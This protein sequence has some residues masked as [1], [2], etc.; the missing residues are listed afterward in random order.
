[1]ETETTFA[2]WLKIQRKQ[3]DIT[4]KQLANEVGCSVSAIRKFEIGAR[5]P[6]KQIAELIAQALNIPTE[7]H[8]RFIKFARSVQS[9]NKSGVFYNSFA[10][11]LDSQSSEAKLV[12]LLTAQARSNNLPFQATNFIGRKVELST[13]ESLVN[14]SAIRLITIVGLGGMGKTRLAISLAEK[15]LADDKFKH[16]CYFV[17]LAA[18]SSSD[19]IPTAIAEAFN[20]S[21]DTQENQR[22]ISQQVLAYLHN[23]EV[24]LILDNFEHLLKG[25]EIVNQIL[26]AAPQLKIIATSRERLSLYSER[27]FRLEGLRTHLKGDQE[28]ASNSESDQLF[29]QSAQ[30]INP[31]FYLTA[32]N[33]KLVTKIC[34]LVGGMPLAIELAAGWLDTLSLSVI[35]AEIQKNLDLLNS[36]LSDLASRHQSIRAVLN[37]SWDQLSAADAT[38]LANFS[39]FRN[40][41]TFEAATSILGVSLSTLK[42]FVDKSLL[43][44]QPNQNR[45]QIHELMRQ[46][47]VE[48]KA[49]HQGESDYVL[50]QHCKYYLTQAHKQEQI[51]KGEDQQNALDTIESEFE[52]IRAAWCYAVKENRWS[53]LRIAAGSLGYFCKW[54]GRYLEGEQLFAIAVEGSEKTESINVYFSP[55]LAIFANIKGN[56]EYADSLLSS[57]NRFYKNRTQSRPD[58]ETQKNEAF[59]CL[60][61]GV[62]YLTKDIARAEMFLSQSLKLYLDLNDEWGR[63]NVTEQL[64]AVQFALTNY[65]KAIEFYEDSKRTF[66]SLGDLRSL[67][68]VLEKLS[69]TGRYSG[70][71]SKSIQYAEQCLKVAEMIGSKPS[72]AQAL[73][74]LSSTYAIGYGDFSQ[75]YQL[76]EE[77][78]KI[79]NELGDKKSLSISF[80]RLGFYLSG[81]GHY[82]AAE[83]HLRESIAL[84]N[85]STMKQWLAWTYQKLGIVLAAKG[86]WS[87]ACLQFQKS[88]DLYGIIGARDEHLLG[89][90]YYIYLLRDQ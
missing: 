70:D 63:A 82:D 7:D 39:V 13:L 12:E 62:H 84:L 8:E 73:D 1:M 9:Q 5:R 52:N 64:G 28:N 56:S 76:Q 3:L 83:R 75:A 54:S 59:V 78:I 19:Q 26:A 58:D 41:F 86:Q 87:E 45:Y 69:R 38:T 89:Y 72:Y 42:K 57:A 35:A 79:F 14:D 21:L 27:V 30:R 44:Y 43:Q 66:S 16:G 20:L 10:Q 37:G 77:C 15:Q 53:L 68:S 4:Q 40:G 90:P 31:E 55:W 17:S 25:A 34:N 29:F 46:Y 71:S 74:N 24:L 81:A 61:L 36:N 88:N 11:Q 2:A 49:K 51:L 23:K 65:D 85:G 33:Q 22:P 32:K 67:I 80:A 50:S 18:L 6:S 60:H 48:M 47:L